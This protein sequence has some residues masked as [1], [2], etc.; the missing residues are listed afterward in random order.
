M[1]LTCSFQLAQY[2]HDTIVQ[3]YSWGYIIWQLSSFTSKPIKSQCFCLY[4]ESPWGPMLFGLHWVFT[5]VQ[6]WFGPHWLSGDQCC[7]GPHYLSVGSIV[8]L[9]LTDFHWGPILFW[10]PLNF[11]KVQC[12]FVFFGLSGVQCCFGPHSLSVGSIVVLGPTYF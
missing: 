9:G 12:F 10:T 8:V 1:P 7:F 6:W 2:K 3:N 4:N 11:S 5:G